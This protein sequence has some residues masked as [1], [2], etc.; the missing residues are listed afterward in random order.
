MCWI[1]L[2]MALHAIHGVSQEL[3]TGYNFCVTILEQMSL[4]KMP[5]I[6]DGPNQN[7]TNNSQDNADLDKCHLDKCCVDKCH[8]ALSRVNR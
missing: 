7:L 5:S 8:F 6:K 2:I 4:W 3:N 1:N